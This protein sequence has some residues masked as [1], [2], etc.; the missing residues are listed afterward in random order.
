MLTVFHNEPAPPQQRSF[1]ETPGID[2][3]WR[4]GHVVTPINGNWFEAPFPTI[5]W[6]W[7]CP[8]RILPLVRWRFGK[9]VGYLGFKAWGVDDPRYLNW[10]H[11]VHVRPGSVALTLS[12][13][14]DAGDH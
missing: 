7:F 10:I 13:R 4:G 5:V 9:V 12:A 6:G 11:D 2:I 8:W 14:F 3:Q 1:R